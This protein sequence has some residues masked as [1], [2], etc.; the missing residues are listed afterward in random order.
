VQFWQD[1][2]LTLGGGID[3]RAIPTRTLDPSAAVPNRFL[4]ETNVLDAADY[5]TALKAAMLGKA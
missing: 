2:V 1:A 3:R 5:E 4:L